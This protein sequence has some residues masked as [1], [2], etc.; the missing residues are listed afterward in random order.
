MVHDVPLG[1]LV[2]G[3]AGLVEKKDRRLAIERTGNS[4]TL[5]LPA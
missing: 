4:N 2:K 5:A 3:G 1:S